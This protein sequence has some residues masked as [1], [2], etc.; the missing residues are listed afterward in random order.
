MKIRKLSLCISMV[1]LLAALPAAYAA[2]AITNCAQVAATGDEN[3]A[4]DKSC[5][6]INVVPTPVSVGDYIWEDTDQDG[7][8]TAGELALVGATVTL[9]DKDGNPAK[10]LT[11]TVVAAVTTDSTGKYL[12]SNL[13]EG[14]YIVNV[15]PPK[16]YIPTLNAGGVND[17]PA[18]DDNNCSAQADGN[19]R[20]ALFNLTGG[21]E[22][23]TAAD[24]DDTNGNL[25]VDCGFYKPTEPTHSLGNKVWVDDGAGTAANANNGVLDAGEKVV[26]DG[27]TLELRDKAGAA[28]TSTTTK[29]GYYLFSGLAAGDYQVCV[30]ASNFAAGATLAGYSASTGGNEADANLNVDSNDNGTDTTADGL[31]SNLITLGADEPTGETDT[32]SGT[33]GDD[34]AGTGDA[35]SNLTV[36]F[37]VIP[38]KPIIP[39]SV[40]N[41]IWEDADNNGTQDAGEKA[42]EGA[43]VTLLDKDGKPAVDLDGK[44]I[45]PI[46]TGADGKYLFS[47][48]PEG[49]YSITVAAPAG[50]IATKTGADADVDT[51]ASDTDS[52]CSAS[53]SGN[54][55]LPFTLSAGGEPDTAADGDGTDGNMTVDCGF[56]KPAAPTHSL[57]NRVWIDTDNN[58]FADVGELPAAMGVK[59][60]LQDSTNAVVGNATTDADGRY[61]FN[62]LAAGSY[63][64]CVVASNF[65]KGAILEGYGASTGGNEADANLDVDGNDN[66]SDDTSKGLCSNAIVLDDKEPT[67]EAT[68]TGADG[69]DG[70]GT[71]DARSNLT[72]DFGI[73]PPP[74]VPVSVGDIIWEDT[75]KDGKQ[76][77]SETPLA[78]A[79]VTLLDKDGNPAKDLTGTAVAAVTTDATGKY[80]F[81][82]LPEGQYQVVFVPPT[83]YVATTAVSDIDG[84]PAND[85][86][87]CAADGKTSLF[88]LS[89]GGEPVDDGDTDAN[90]NLSVDCGFYKPTEPTHSLGNKVW[91]DDGAGTAANANNGTLDAGEKVVA[92]GVT[93][94]LRDKAGAAITSTTTKDGYYLFSGLA[95]GDYQ[96][97]VVASNFAAGATLAG[98]GA[99]TGGNEADA[100]LNV[101]SNDNGTDTTADGLCSNL[102]T[103]GADE[104]TG[105]TDTA[106]GT[107]GDDGAGTGDALSNLTVDFAVIPPP[108]KPV[109]PVSVGNYI[110]DDADK[111]GQQDAGE[112]GL[113]GA[114]VSLVDGAD[115][116]ATDVDGK[117]LAPIT[118]GADGKYLFSNLPEGDYR[119]FVEQ[120]ADYVLTKG[121]V[122]VDLDASDTDNNCMAASLSGTVQ[123]QLFTLTA[124]AEPDAAADGDDTN[125]NLTVDCGFYKPT[126]PTHSLGNKVWV[127]DGAGTAANANNG[128]LDAGEKVV[129]DGVTLELRDKAGAAI[130]STT[131][132]DGYY[133]FSG[134]AAG[135]YQVCVVASNFAAGAT[136]AGYS[137]STGG[138]EADANSNVD[139]NDNGTDTTADGLC[140]N[141]ITLGADEP[142]GETD[143]ASGTAGDDGAG[144]G[145]ALS[146]LTV[147]FAVIPPK[148]IIPVSVG[149][150]IWEDADNNG[151]QDAG[152]KALEGATVTLLDKDGKPAVDLDGKA[153]D[154]ITTGV[155][156]KY[157]FSNLPEGDYSITVAAP[158]GYIATKTGADA[159]VD[160]NASDTDSNCSA[161]ASGNTTLPFTLSA[162]GEPDTAADGDGTDGNMTVD[163]GF[164]KPAAPTHSLGNRV[165]IDTDNNGLADVGE[166]P[167]A[168]GVKLELQDST[169]AVVG[170]AT[171][172]ADGRY[173]FNGLAAGS[174]TVCVVASNF[175]KGAILEGYG[176]STGG[177]EAD[178]NLDVDGNDNGSDDTAKGLCSNAIVLDDKEPTLEATA[179][180]AD[181]ND[182]TGTEDARSNLTIDFGITPPPAVPVSVGDIIWE[183]TDKDGKQGASETPLAGAQVT[184]LDKDGNP[185][186]DLTG[187]AVAAVTTDATGKYLFSNLPE[188]QYQVVFVPPTGYVATTAVSD[189]DGTPAN[190]DSNCAA[191]G[192]TSL[193]SLSVG[194][195]P[196]DDGDTDAN[197]NLSVDCGFYKEAT[198]PPTSVSVGDY[199]WDDTNKD[200]KQDV[201]E[202]ALAGATVTLLTKDGSPVVLGDIAV[203]PVITDVDGKYLFSGLPEGDYI[204]S[205]APPAGYQPSPNAGGVD[206][207]PA[208][209]DSNCAA[210]GKTAPF[211]LS[212]A[213]EPDTADDGDNTSSNLSVD[214]G[215]Y[216]PVPEPTH[217]VGN[218]VWVDDGAG[219]AANANNGKRDAG[220]MA[221]PDGVVMELR[222][223]DG[224]VLS[225]TPTDKG[226]YVFSGL[227]AGEYSVCVAHGNFD[228]GLLKGYTASA[229]GDEVD[230]NADGDN[231]DNGE[232]DL[233]D[234]LCSNNIILDDKEPAGE[235]PT[236]S[237]NAGDDGAGTED[238]RSNL[239]V[240]FGVLP[241]A[242][243]EPGTPVAVGN[244]IWVDT[245]GDGIQD[246]TEKGLAAAKITLTDSAGHAVNDKD[247]QPVAA[248]TTAADGAYKF[249]NLNDGDYI[250]T[251]EPP[252]GYYL[253]LGGIDVDD[254]ASD[255]DSN[256]RV[257][258]LNSTIETHPFT[259]TAGTEPG[260]D[261]DDANGDM[262]VDCGFYGPVSLGN[263][264][265]LDSDADGQQDSAE[266]GIEGAVITL[267]DADGTTPA[268]DI[269]GKAVAPVTTDVTGNYLFDNLKPGDYVV[270]VKPQDGYSLTKGG[271]DADDDTSDKDSNC[272]VAGSEFMT[273]AVT[274]SPGSEPGTKV[275]GDDESRNS[276][277]DCGF[278]RAVSLGQRVWIDLDANG[279]QDAGEP[280]VPGATVTLL[281]ASGKPATDLYGK[282]VAP[283]T[284]DAD[285]NYL[286]GSLSEGSY[287]I[288]VTPPP[289][290]APTMVVSDPNNNDNTDSNGVPQTDGSVISNP[291][292]LKWGEEPQGGGASNITVGFGFIPNLQIPTLSEWGVAIMS[293]LL[294]TAAF[295]R[296]RRED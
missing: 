148:P 231:N 201:G 248:Q 39:V 260:T 44:A 64:V 178:A 24:G 223:K 296:R 12:F 126:E 122:D 121:G 270:K 117:V 267:F 292:D 105:E 77:A 103:L 90:S 88:S 197:S 25:T 97:C 165:W 15:V 27:V 166:L 219:T 16:G 31:C 244:R 193:F 221:V 18:N 294:A 287:L 57:G 54:T 186:K 73:T 32:A 132:K 85:D 157:L 225:E 1:G 281:D 161:S 65:D 41:Y 107:A 274:L 179:T 258:P 237:G 19:I 143:T 118:V 63:T 177:N 108:P 152:E 34:G 29:D 11:G 175:D 82:N 164:Y 168:M 49:D 87:N 33:A 252:A 182:G 127:D 150:Y 68:A 184:L 291:I 264:I 192:K 227:A 171:T 170:N 124:G 160:T 89:V 189:I 8:Q 202:P 293:M 100:N 288:K 141:L 43:T 155:D 229:G 195:E 261:G 247:G 111:N 99:S 154:P 40:G 232:N 37:A 243:V 134:L 217:S 245:N 147:D 220:E 162:G 158:A 131:T 290:Y 5:V 75:D 215:F 282:V 295:F 26:A 159:D 204:V 206:D 3:P 222:D 9:L 273:P 146:N 4:N 76:G 233:Q 17:V 272:K 207:V 51:N 6:D 38:P 119:I 47:N 196:V 149:N 13:P 254:D 249:T 214:C 20:T 69:N 62:G 208:N 125:G 286:F 167:A 266:A 200:G 190:D 7:K 136:L 52:N 138:N 84:T 140:S 42:L 14:D 86:S 172:D 139:S 211:N 78:G 262:T 72:I 102:I 224:I 104:P 174:Y 135:D 56:Y 123:T 45:D 48:L 284:T 246:G 55:S 101:D 91:V 181:G 110:W 198:P 251:V 92:D 115:R 276:T 191:D 142:T 280:G 114:I 236:A 257:N 173:L 66:G 128:T 188:G 137:A 144:T 180:G 203:G 242:P 21:A 81:S 28:I 22:P 228:L 163:C 106:S 238:A 130:T 289:G 156:G 59:L 74:A 275:D 58:G 255:T 2:D 10:D 153:I 212:I 96:V 30:V 176:A 187:T 116:P 120:P 36:D 269:N 271:A 60:E 210:D 133:L 79:Q 145:D 279:K 285:G 235:L 93:L 268:T 94:E 226:Y 256:C 253:T 151:T 67:L 109:V 277:L 239:T 46:T 278:F 265:W 199:I 95:A 35:L 216:K 70:T 112:K 71:E 283:Q 169:N 183:D 240:D 23:D 50:Y 98:Y 218:M 61:L 194:G 259:L 230:A 241:P 83:G 250:V 205:V 129:A 185:A 113:E 80:L 263:K 213:G 53:A 234:G 209:N